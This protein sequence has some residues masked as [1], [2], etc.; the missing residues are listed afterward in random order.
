[1]WNFVSGSL[2][3]TVWSDPSARSTQ[4]AG[5]NRIIRVLQRLGGEMMGLHPLFTLRGRR[6]EHCGGDFARTAERQQ[7][8]CTLAVAP[9]SRIV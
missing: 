9:R 3:P 7:G 4:L 6:R 2:S 1:M 8:V 5:P